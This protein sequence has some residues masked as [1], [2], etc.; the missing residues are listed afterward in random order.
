M[1]P[2]GAARCLF[3]LFMFCPIRC[4]LV[5]SGSCLLSDHLLRQRELVAL[6]IFDLRFVYCL[7]WFL[8]AYSW[9]K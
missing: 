9:C 6:L 8:S 7:S 2:C 3:F 5:F 1:W 4:F